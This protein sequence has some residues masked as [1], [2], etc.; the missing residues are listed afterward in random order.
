[1]L[2]STR[3][4]PQLIV[5]FQMSAP[6]AKAGVIN[7]IAAYSMWGFAPLY[8]KAL[9]DIP[10]AEILMHRVVWSVIL[11]AILI[12]ALN[13]FPQVRL[14]LKRPRVLLTLF[15]SGLLLGG[16]WL[17]YIWAVNSGHIL[18]ASLGY[19]I[20]PLLNVLLGYLF[21]QERLRP[22]QV[23]AVALAF[24]GVAYLVFSHGH[25]PWIA[26]VLAASFGIYGLLRKRVAVDS[27]PGLTI[28]TSMMLPAALIYWTFFAGPS[29]VLT[30]NSTTLNLLLMFAGVVTTAPLLCFTAAAKRLQYSTLGFFQYIGPS[31]MF[32][33]AVVLY[34]EPLEPER[35]TTFA[36]VWTALVIFSLDSLRH[37]RK[38]KRQAVEL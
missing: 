23:F 18:E 10:A 35:L 22:M 36:F 29:A 27:L 7:A 4:A 16:N 26:L 30:D 33:L 24:I 20:N 15:V 14:A 19:Y 1:M 8:F 25:L 38:S 11:L 31:L 9:Q 5:D 12:A 21:L 37:Y 3:S 34:R 6:S 2:K 13:K 28:E 32:I 17:L